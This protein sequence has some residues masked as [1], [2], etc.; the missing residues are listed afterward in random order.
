MT[1]SHA[2]RTVV[3][4]RPTGDLSAVAASSG[5]DF[6]RGLL[7]DPDAAPPIFA[8]MNIRAISFEHGLAVFE[9]IPDECHYNPLG[10]VHGG[11]ASTVLDT[12]LGCAVHSALP[13]GSAYTTLELKVNLVRP[14]TTRTGALTCEGRTIHV[15][16]RTATADAKLFGGDGKLYAHG[17]TTCMVFPVP[18]SSQP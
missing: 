6:L 3:W 7:A 15:G 17:S 16:G 1:A 13:A 9:A 18:A 14:I 11:W 12:A 8:L 4:R 2:S 5:L 10:T